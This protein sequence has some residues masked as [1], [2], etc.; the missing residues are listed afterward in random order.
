MKRKI[1]IITV[2]IILLLIGYFGAKAMG[3]I[4]ED[5]SEIYSEAL[6]SVFTQRV[7]NGT[8]SINLEENGNLVAE[9][10]IEI[11]SEVQGVLQQG[12]KDFKPGVFYKK[13]EVILRTDSKEFYASI[14]AQR[15]SLQN[16]IASIMPDLRLDYPESYLKWEQ[17]LNGF[18]LDK[19]TPKLPKTNSNQEKLFITSRNIL[20]TYYNI[21]NLEERL[22]KYVIRAPF[23]GVLTEA[24]VTKGA[25]V[26]SGQKLGV[27]IDPSSFELEIN[28]N[29]TYINLLEIGGSVSLR[30][31]SNSQ[32]W[33]G[34]VKRING[35]VDSES[36]TI[37]VFITVKG[38]DLREG[39]FLKAVIPSKIKEQAIEIP[40]NLL[41]NEN[42]VYAVEN[43]QLLLITIDVLYYNDNTVVIKGVPNQTLLVSTPMASAYVGM[44]VKPI[45]QD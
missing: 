40:L 8:V 32:Q 16:M 41:I 4:S 26:R 33:E 18:D 15:S 35:T 39:M 43:N 17:Y 11:Y 9:N 3:N 25:L 28:L 45:Q 14:L 2:C 44:K 24:N 36:R 20:T 22:S 13:G 27:F 6:K 34:V 42:A 31:M 7:N 1:I 19:T 23:D 12:R 30:N 21:K 10:K 37:K 5:N 29:E 38:Q